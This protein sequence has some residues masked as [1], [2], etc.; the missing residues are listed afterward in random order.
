RL[1]EIARART[2]YLLLLPIFVVLIVFVYY[3]PLSALVYSFFAWDPTAPSQQFVGWANYVTVLQD[4]HFGQEV[5][6]MLVLLVATVVT[7]VTAPLVVAELIYAV[8]NSGA[9]YAYRFLFLV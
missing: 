9:R 1:Q 7:S 4:P 5:L 3:P 8:R 6:N 2:S